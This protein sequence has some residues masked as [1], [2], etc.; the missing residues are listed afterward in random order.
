M[1]GSTFLLQSFQPACTD[2]LKYEA[3]V[4]FEESLQE[5]SEKQTRQNKQTKTKREAKYWVVEETKLLVEHTHAD[6]PCRTS[7][8]TKEVRQ[9]IHLK[10]N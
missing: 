9:G 5:E 7:E 10:A 8:A 6:E 1:T 4:I 3:I 2:K